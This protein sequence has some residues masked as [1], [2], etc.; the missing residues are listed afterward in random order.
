MFS[1]IKDTHILDRCSK[2]FTKGE[3]IMFSQNQ[4]YAYK[5]ASINKVRLHIKYKMLSLS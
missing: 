3:F 2:I 1:N 4:K 5:K